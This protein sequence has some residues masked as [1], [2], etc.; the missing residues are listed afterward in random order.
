MRR[1]ET[2]RDRL[3][4]V[5]FNRRKKKK[6]REKYPQKNGQKWAKKAFLTSQKPNAFFKKRKKLIM[7]MIMIMIMKMIMK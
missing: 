2:E 7:I 3:R 5:F 4:P 1:K 6:K